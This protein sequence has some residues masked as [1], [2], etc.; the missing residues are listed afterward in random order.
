MELIVRLL[1]AAATVVKP[2]LIPQQ[3]LQL[4]ARLVRTELFLGGRDK[5]PLGQFK[6]FAIVCQMLFLN[7]IGTPVATLVGHR[8]IK[9]RAVETDF[10]V[11]ATV[12]R[13]RATG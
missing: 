11:R 13:F 7:R 4:I 2:W 1:T 3:I 10:K 9:A 12:A 5:K 6:P 8:A